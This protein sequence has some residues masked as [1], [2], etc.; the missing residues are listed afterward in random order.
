MNKK[1]QLLRL[2]A[3]PRHF[4]L[5]VPKGQLRRETNAQSSLLHSTLM[6]QLWGKK[7]KQTRTTIKWQTPLWTSQVTWHYDSTS[8]PI[9]ITNVTYH[10]IILRL[11]HNTHTSL[12]IQRAKTFL[13]TDTD[14]GISEYCCVKT[15]T[16]L[17]TKPAVASHPRNSRYGK[18]TH[19]I[20]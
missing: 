6:S 5:F 12:M 17:R 7:T 11:S 13:S 18:D 2:V 9:R 4:A 19:L 15:M 8:A 16:A 10:L 3:I 14:V 20:K 1:D